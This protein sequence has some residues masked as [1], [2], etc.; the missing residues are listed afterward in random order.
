MPG[1]GEAMAE[2]ADLAAFIEHRLVRHLRHGDSGHRHVGR[3]QCFRDADRVRLE[4]EGGTAEHGSEPAEAADHLVRD[5]VDVVFPADLHHL[6]K[7]PLRR[8]DHAAGAHHRLGDE[9]GNRVRVLFANEIL[10]LVRQSPRE[11]RFGLARMRQ[12]VMVRASRVQNSRDRQI[13]IAVIVRQSRERGRCNGHT[14]IGIAA[15]DDLLFARPAERI[16]HVPD[17]LDLA[18]VRLR[19]R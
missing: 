3:R 6:A 2:G 12:A 15:A 9:G 10:E 16:V 19:A 14:V 5:H 7:V 18:V 4:A 13:E 1:I 8:Y 17:E 11:F